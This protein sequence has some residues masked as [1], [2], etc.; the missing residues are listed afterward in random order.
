M[1]WCG[2]FVHQPKGGN[3]RAAAYEML[4]DIE[5]AAADRAEAKNLV[6]KLE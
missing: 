5:K 3:Y 4:G 6:P 1:V 2:Q